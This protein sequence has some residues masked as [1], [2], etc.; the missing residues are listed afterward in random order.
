MTCEL[1]HPFFATNSP[2]FHHDFVPTDDEQST[3]PNFR[4][5]VQYYDPGL[6]VQ[7]RGA[8]Y[9]NRDRRNEHS[10]LFTRSNLR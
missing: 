6:I 10:L 9:F 3:V 7:Q 1:S 5:S 8:V 2:V 4:L